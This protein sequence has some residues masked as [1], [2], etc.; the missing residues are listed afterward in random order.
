[1]SALARQWNW[2]GTGCA[3]WTAMSGGRNRLVPRTQEKGVRSTEVSKCTTCIRP[4]T[5]VSVRPA[6]RVEIGWAANRARAAS[7]LSCTV[8]PES[9]LCQPWYACPL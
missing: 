5:P 2:S 3:H 8:R 4:W 6:H 1:V 7:S 9:W